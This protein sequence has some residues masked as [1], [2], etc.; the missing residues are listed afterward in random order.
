MIKLLL[1]SLLS[2]LAL[3]QYNPDLSKNLCQLTVASYCRPTKIVDWSCG[4]C[5][6]SSL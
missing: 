5:K 3:S 1:F 6:T 2:L 4:P